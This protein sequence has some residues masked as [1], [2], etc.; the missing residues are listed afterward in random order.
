MGPIIISTSVI[1]I[2]YLSRDNGVSCTEYIE[3]NITKAPTKQLGR[4]KGIKFNFLYKS[5]EALRLGIRGRIVV[6]S[7]TDLIGWGR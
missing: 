4:R 6:I 5:Y 1:Y 3:A 7:R 2:V